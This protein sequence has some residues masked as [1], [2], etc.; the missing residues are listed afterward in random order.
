MATAQAAKRH[1]HQENPRNLWG[2]RNGERIQTAAWRD[3]IC[4][5]GTEKNKKPKAVSTEVQMDA[6]IAKRRKKRKQKK[7]TLG[8]KLV[9]NTSEMNKFKNFAKKRKI[10]M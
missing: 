5:L 3:K 6:R 1:Q 7:A 9:E 2:K 8:A 4:K 10:T